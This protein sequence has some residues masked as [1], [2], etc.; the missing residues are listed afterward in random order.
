[1]V[2]IY[3]IWGF[4]I[5]DWGVALFNVLPRATEKIPIL[6]NWSGRGEGK[7]PL[8]RMAISIKTQARFA[9]NVRYGNL[10]LGKSLDL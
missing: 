2:C 1:M 9:T 5:R 3:G 10:I 4:G 6:H 7:I 8:W